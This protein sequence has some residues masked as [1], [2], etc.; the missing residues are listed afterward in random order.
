MEGSA[1]PHALAALGCVLGWLLWSMLLGALALRLPSAWL[2]R[3]SWLTR[4]R[5]WGESLQAYEHRLQI[6]RWKGALPDAGDAFPGGLRKSSLV[7]REPRQLRQ[8]IAETRRAELVHLGIWLFWPFTALWLPGW[9]VLLNLVFAT[10][11]NLPCLWVQRFNRLRL[12]RVLERMESAASGLPPPP[13]GVRLQLNQLAGFF[14]RSISRRN[15][16]NR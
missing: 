6:R 10:L 7:V 5:P 2:E 9:A 3:D 13:C 11:F 4:P 1:H 14:S 12:R 15:R 16:Q 8:L